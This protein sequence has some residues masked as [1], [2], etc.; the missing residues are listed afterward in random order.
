[1]TKKFRLYILNAFKF[2]IV[3]NLIKKRKNK[4][5]KNKKVKRKLTGK[6]SQQKSTK[7]GY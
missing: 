5:L 4:R 1:M 6:M 7:N 2:N 3:D